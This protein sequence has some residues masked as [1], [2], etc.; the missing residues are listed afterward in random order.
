MKKEIFWKRLQ[1]ILYLFMRRRNCNEYVDTFC[2]NLREIV[3]CCSYHFFP[4]SFSNLFLP[5]F[6]QGIIRLFRL[7]HFPFPLVA[8]P[9]PLPSQET[10]DLEMFASKTSRAR[11]PSPASAYVNFLSLT[12]TPLFTTLIETFHALY[13]QSHITW[14]SVI[15]WFP[16]N[17]GPF[18]SLLFPVIDKVLF[19]E[20][21]GRRVAENTEVTHFM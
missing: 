18:I 4:R 10:G 5:K 19:L 20:M 13:T 3:F 17:N 15:S 6:S 12:E 8:S 16:F 9:P 21:D 7:A 1:I 14:A 11:A 2:S